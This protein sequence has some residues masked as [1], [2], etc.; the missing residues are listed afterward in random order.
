MATAQEHYERLLAQH[1]T[2]MFGVPF[3]SKVKEQASLLRQAGVEAPGLALDLGCGPGF[4]SLALIKL[5]AR[6]VRAIDSSPALLRELEGHAGKAA[7]TT[8]EAD[9][10]D[11][12]RLVEEPADCIVCMGDTL[13]HLAD[14]EQVA[15]LLRKAA[16]RLAAG[17]RLVLSW[18]DLSLSPEGHERFILLR[19]TEDRILTCFLEDQ[20]DRVLVHDLLHSLGAEGWRLQTSAYPKLKLAG[21]DVISVLEAAGLAVERRWISGGMIVLAATK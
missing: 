15:A 9:L 13:T 2:W 10:L 7:I 17:G 20:G 12:D 6:E 14:R 21:G 1:Y 11:F 18:R 3:A 8:H 16:D 5:D 19:A 4:Q